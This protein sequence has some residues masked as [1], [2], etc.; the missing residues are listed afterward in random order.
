MI[1]ETLTTSVPNL[2]DIR[3]RFKLGA[4]WENVPLMRANGEKEIGLRPDDSIK[5]FSIHHSAVEGDIFGHEGYHVRKGYPGVAYHIYLKR[6]RRMLCNHPLA[7]TWHTQSNNYDTLSICIEGNYTARNLTEIERDNLN[8]MIFRLLPIFPNVSLEDVRGH[9][10]WTS[11][12]QTSCPGFDMNRVR[13]DVYSL[14]QRALFETS[15]ARKKEM[16][17]AVAN[18]VMFQYNLM[19]G[20]LSDGSPATPGQIGWSTETMMLLYP[21]MKERGLVK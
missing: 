8:D 19:Q 9:W 20:K 6:E 12:S 5:R 7:L 2:L 17:F 21:F 4:G 15:A 11:K 13:S 16:A 3:D 14:Q 18:Q 10:E 1:I